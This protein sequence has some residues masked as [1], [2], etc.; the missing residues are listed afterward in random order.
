M[1]RTLKEDK[2]RCSHKGQI[3][4][5]EDAEFDGAVAET[6]AQNGITYAK[7]AGSGAQVDPDDPDYPFRDL[8]GIVLPDEIGANR[9]TLTPFR[10]GRVREYAYGATDRVSL[11]YH[12][13]HDIAPNR[14]AFIHFHWAHNGTAISG[15]LQATFSYTYAKG[16]YQEIFIPEKQLTFNIPI[17][18]INS[19]PRWEHFIDEIPIFTEL[20]SAT[21]LSWADIEPD[22]LLE[23]DLTVDVI[24]TIT[25]GAPNEPF[26]LTADLHYRS[27]GTGTKQKAPDFY[28]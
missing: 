6:I 28:T 5:F 23:A 10:G 4:N 17:T 16:H 21:E 7:E 22:A 18:D 25:G 14:D 26:I 12:M 3:Y 13:P 1:T 27:T 8:E 15:T 19:H 24:P 9:P 2:P 11:R 20:G